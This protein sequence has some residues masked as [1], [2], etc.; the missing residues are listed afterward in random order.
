[1]RRPRKCKK[2]WE[3]RWNSRNF[4]PINWTLNARK[5]AFSWIH[6]NSLSQKTR[7]KSCEHNKTRYFP[8][9]HWTVN[10]GKQAF[11]WIHAHLLSRKMQ[12][13]HKKAS[14][15]AGIYHNFRRFTE[16]WT[17]EN[18]RFLEFTWIHYPRKY[19]K[20]RENCCE[21]RNTLCFP[22]VN[23][24]VNSGKRCVLLNLP[25][26]AVLENKGKCRFFIC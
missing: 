11:S 17:L 18:M 12:E 6:P 22:Y 24:A 19:K 5:Q 4:P 1:M 14:V 25:V 9:V 16:R 10:A 23:R 7:G 8:D 13:K 26:F 2:M 3:K 21:R 15:N 20:T